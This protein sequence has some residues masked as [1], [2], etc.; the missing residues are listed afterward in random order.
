MARSSGGI[1]PVN[2]QME[3]EVCHGGNLHLPSEGAKTS[4]DFEILKYIS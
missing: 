1:R 3:D 2:L 4:S